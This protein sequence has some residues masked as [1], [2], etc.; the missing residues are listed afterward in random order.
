MEF[1]PLILFIVYLQQLQPHSQFSPTQSP[2]HEHSVLHAWPLHDDC[3]QQSLL[4]DEFLLMANKT[5]L[6]AMMANAA[7]KITF[8]FM[9]F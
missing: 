2:P 1:I 6:P 3:L 7:N 5:L 8:F 4:D 9:I